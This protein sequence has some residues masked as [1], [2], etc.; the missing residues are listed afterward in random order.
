M[1][2]PSNPVS[3]GDTTKKSY[4]DTLYDNA[5]L[6][7]TGGVAG[8]AQTIPGKKDFTNGI[9]VDYITPLSAGNVIGIIT[10]DSET[11]NSDYGSFEFNYN[12]I[13]WAQA[14]TQLFISN[15]A[16]NDSAGDWKFKKTDQASQI[17]MGSSGNI[18]F[19]T[20]VSGTED[21]AITWVSKLKIDNADDIIGIGGYAGGS[22]RDSYIYLASDAYIKWNETEDRVYINKKMTTQEIQPAGNKVWDVGNATYAWDTMYADDYTNVADFYH[23][24]SHD[25]IAAIMQIKGRGEIDPR[26]G[27]EIIDDDTLPEWLLLKSK[28]GKEIERTEDGRPYLSL[29]TIDSLCMGAI[30]QLNLK[31]EAQQIQINE[32]KGVK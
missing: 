16:Y 31:I 14:S 10:T 3:I 1:A 2:I 24:D 18:L 30:R 12:S 5:I 32:L 23:L 4:Y 21:T 9:G 22:N 27:L 8:G 17:T 15:N 25:D 11:W 19:K 6:C 26:S 13:A 29:K 7:D 20:S 28:D